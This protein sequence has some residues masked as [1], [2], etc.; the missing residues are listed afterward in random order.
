LTV[1]RR[2]TTT[3]LG[4][5]T[6]LTVIF[7]LLVPGLASAAPPT[8]LTLTPEN[9]SIPAGNCN[10]FTVTLTGATQTDI[11]GQTIDVEVRD[12]DVGQTTDANTPVHFC[13]PPATGG[14]YDQNGPNPQPVLT[15]EN[16]NLNTDGSC[17]WLD[18]Q[19][20]GCDGTVSGETGTTNSSGQITFGI[21]SNEPGTYQVQAY[22]EDE[23]GTTATN[24]VRDT[25]DPGDTS[26]KTFTQFQFQ[27]QCSDQADNDGD[28][29]IDNGSDPGCTSPTDNDET[30]P[31]VGPTANQCE[32]GFDN[33]HD[34]LIDF[35]S[36]GG[37]KSREDNSEVGTGDRRPATAVTIR[38]NK[39]VHSFKGT[40]TSDVKKCRVNRP[41]VLK[42]DRKNKS[43]FVFKK[44]KTDAK[45]N[46]LFKVKKKKAL[47]KR[48]YVK[49]K[50]KSFN[51][52]NGGVTTCLKGRSVTIKLKK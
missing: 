32:D 31:V 25:G 47:G 24:D 18:F 21:I 14:A 23:G 10:A 22:W 39:P 30:D 52:P 16:Q 49:A 28:G 7:A 27:P 48:W 34:G 15:D 50:P 4:L 36:D 1:R 2:K 29:L 45:G 19:A 26:G 38:Y 5:L 37:C 6:A 44:G 42:R 46:Y 43:D 11:T 8:G 3:Y 13:T 51:N 33:D 17:E 41:V 9:D 35:G 40:V 12:A 20:P